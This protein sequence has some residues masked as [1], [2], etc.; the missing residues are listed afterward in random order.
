YTSIADVANVYFPFLP[1]R[2]LL[3]DRFD[4]AAKA[5]RVTVPV[6]VVHGTDDEVIPF[7]LGEK[8]AGMFPNA[9]LVALPRGRHNDLFL[10]G[11]DALVSDLER[12][13]R[14]E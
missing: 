2:W 1:N 4:N 10:R 14:A 8:L 13:C 11:G 6:L 12:F 5:P 7:A 9:R 3:R